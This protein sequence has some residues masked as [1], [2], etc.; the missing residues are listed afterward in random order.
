ASLATVLASDPDLGPNGRVTYRLLDSEVMGGPISTYVSVDPATGAIY[1]LRTFNFEILKQLELTIQATDGGSP[2]LSSTAVVNVRVLDQNDNAP[3]ITHPALTNG[4]LEI[5]VS[6]KAARDSV[7]AHIRARDADEGVN[8]E[9]SFSLLEDPQRQQPGA[10]ELFAMDKRT[11]EV[12]LTRSFS[13]E[14]LGYVY[15]LLL[16]VAD[17]GQPP[18]ST[19]ATVS[20]QVTAQLPPSSGQNLVAKRNAWEGKALQWD[21]PLIVI[22]ILAGSCTLLLVAIITIATTCNRRKK[23]KG[24]LEEPL[25]ASHLEKGLQEDK[26][27][28]LRAAGN[29]FEGHSFASKSSFTSPE[30]SPASEDIPVSESSR[31]SASLYDSQSRLRGAS[32]ESYASTPS[33]SKEPVPPVAIWKGHSFNTILG[34]EAEKFSG[35]DSGKGDSDFNDS[36]SD[37]SGDALKK[38]LITH[39]QNG[40]WACTSEC[41]I[42]GHSDR[43]WS[44]SC[45]RSN[46]HPSP[47]PKPRLSTFCKSTSLPRDSLRR[48]NYYQAQLPKT[49]GLQSVYEKVLHRD[50]DRTLALLSPP[51]PG[52]LPDLQEISVPVYQAPAP[53]YLGPPPE[54]TQKV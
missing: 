23:K 5:G 22:I 30:P 13:E 27:C 49:V 26:P 9:L 47:R 45:G 28:S 43:C 3:V 20:F 46:P 52:R 38:D 32:A 6:S 51:H 25:N 53:C 21:I 29:S 42:L 34:R 37:I 14:Q 8:S 15:P 10:L 54:S 33:Y 35:K 4:S 19:T 39:M 40:L 2:P 7:V 17:N 31:E 11:G 12:V 18:L 44:P 24:A 41:K 36:D 50:H 48:D 16:V 1:T